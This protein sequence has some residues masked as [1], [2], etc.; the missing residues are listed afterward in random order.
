M[1][2]PTTAITSPVGRQDSCSFLVMTLLIASGGCDC[3]GHE[4]TEWP[5]VQQD[6][7]ELGL[8]LTPVGKIELY[9]H[10][11]SLRGGTALLRLRVSQDE[12][13]R[14]MGELPVRKHEL[15][16]CSSENLRVQ[17]GDPALWQLP[18]GAT[19]VRCAFGAFSHRGED[20]RLALVA[21]DVQSGVVAFLEMAW[22][23]D[24]P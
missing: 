19:K 14:L 3:G 6:L 18:T 20:W 16:P 2:T 21:A 13:Q 9:Q 22:D 7:H 23:I 12:L 11:E 10:D 15:E 5:E 17:Q 8:K 4:L 1:T 24:K